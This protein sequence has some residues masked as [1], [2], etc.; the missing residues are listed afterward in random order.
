MIHDYNDLIRLFNGLFRDAEN[1]VLVAGAGE[2][3]Y[4][5]ADGSCAEDRVIFANG[6]FASALHEV[7]HWCIAGA[8]RRRLVDFDY[9]YRPD[10]RTAD[11]QLEFERVEVKPQALEWIFSVASGS[12]F[13]LSLDNLSGGRSGAEELFRRNVERQAQRYI[14]EGMPRRALLFQQALVRHYR[15]GE[16]VRASELHFFMPSAAQSA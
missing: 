16:P 2:P 10:G 11:Q 5:P 13:T 3:L 1:T 6:F 4:Q 9:W 15:G 14:L 12:R 7:S 8:A